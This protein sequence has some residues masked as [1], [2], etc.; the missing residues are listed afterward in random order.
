MS[1]HADPADPADPPEKRSALPIVLIVVAVVVVVAAMVGGLIWYRYANSEKAGA[2]ASELTDITPQLSAGMSVE[3][4]VIDFAS[5]PEFSD[6]S[7]SPS[8]RMSSSSGD[9]NR[10][11][12]ET[13]GRRYAPNPRF[14]RNAY[15]D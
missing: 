3:E 13:F 8:P 12:K 7:P 6:S 2:G 14:K 11:F 1:D 9:F 15:A 5:F 4:P 10:A